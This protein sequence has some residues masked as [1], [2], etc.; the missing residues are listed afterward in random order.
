MG[1]FSDDSA[2]A[3][4]Y[5][6]V[7]TDQNKNSWTPELVGSAAAY[8]ASKKYDDHAE[9]YGAP[10]SLADAKHLIAGLAGV[11][12]DGLLETKG[13]DFI[14]KARTRD[15]AAKQAADAYDGGGEGF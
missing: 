6:Q 3:D 8:E 9:Q 7:T 15:E 13:I 12:A 5:N 10:A 1:F 14:D 2:H 11:A 4:A